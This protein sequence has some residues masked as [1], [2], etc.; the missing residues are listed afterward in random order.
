[1]SIKKNGGY[2]YEYDK[3][4]KKKKEKEVVKVYLS[5]HLRGVVS[6]M[7]LPVR[8]VSRP[9]TTKSQDAITKPWIHAVTVAL[10]A[11]LF[12]SGFS[13]LCSN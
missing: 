10:S 5:A 11:V 7:L 8:Y 13:L 4:K 1:M 9:G 3:G 6:I 12:V 2:E